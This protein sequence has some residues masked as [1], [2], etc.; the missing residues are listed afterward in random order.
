MQNQLVEII[1]SSQLFVP[2][3]SLKIFDE[4][5]IG[6]YW[7][8]CKWKGKHDPYENTDTNDKGKG[9]SWIGMIISEE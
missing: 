5:I 4:N 9:V 7:I 8:M 3:T 1:K 2:E 6:T